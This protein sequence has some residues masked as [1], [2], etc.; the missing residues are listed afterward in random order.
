MNA[1]RG[2]SRLAN[3]TRGC[4]GRIF[5]P[6]SVGGGESRCGEGEPLRTTSGEA[7]SPSGGG[8]AAPA[9]D[10][11]DWRAEA[12]RQKIHLLRRR[13]RGLVPGETGFSGEAGDPT[14]ESGL[15]RTRSPRHKANGSPDAASSRPIDQ[16]PRRSTTRESTGSTLPSKSGVLFSAAPGRCVLREARERRESTTKA[17]HSRQDPLATRQSPAR[18]PAGVVKRQQIRHRTDVHRLTSCHLIVV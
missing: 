8:G 9:G 5:R 2:P 7:D 14:N 11:T 4:R 1:D 12:L 16:R 6:P 10:R 13:S 17:R 15:S 3:Q 18:R